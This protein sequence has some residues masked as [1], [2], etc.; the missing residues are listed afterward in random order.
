LWLPRKQD[1]DPL[2]SESVPAKRV[3]WLLPNWLHGLLAVV[4][5]AGALALLVLGWQVAGSPV[6]VMVDGH[7]YEL[8]THAA[9]VAGVL[10]QAGLDLYPE[11]WVSPGP[12]VAL[13]PGL[14]VDVWRAW[15]VKLHVDGRTRHI[16]THATTVGQL[17]AEAGVQAGPADEIW[18]GEQ[19]VGPDALLGGDF[20]DTRAVSSRGGSRLAAQDAVAEPPLISLRRAASL[21][22]DDGGVV[23]RLQTTAQTVGQVL[24]EYG[25]GLFLGDEVTPGLQARVEP[26]MMVAIQRSVPVKIVVDG[27]TIRTRTLAHTV[28]GVLG[29]ESVALVGQ[30][31]VEPALAAPIAAGMAIHITRRRE[32]LVVEFDP[33]PFATILVPD[34][35][36]EIDQQRLVQAGQI[37]L[38]KHRFRVLYENGRET[39]RFLED[40]WAEQPPITKTLA[41]GTKIVVRTLDT[42]AGP[43][44]YWR[45]IRVY[46][47]SYMPASCGKPKSDPRYG[48][49]RLGWKLQKGIVAVDPTVIPLRTT[50]YVPGYGLARAGDTGGAVLGKFVDLG[51]SDNDYQS[52]HWWTDI[53]LLAP[54]PPAS[55]IR[56][57]LPNWPRYPDRR[58]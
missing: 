1:S 49:T 44:E 41:Y 11:D 52:W 43:I 36:L 23:Q 15:P 33:I 5:L 8:R 35:E 18:L 29:Q 16:R 40:T 56:W 30:D 42:P 27:R 45:K 2:A 46:T 50:M 54:V 53:Y 12:E 21:L 38:T 34:P 32:E 26:G 28:A 17:L 13:A 10:Q 39:E 57:V 6:V 58:R 48:Y 22:L 51:F 9:T 55:Q 7:R 37:G 19:Q 20:S 47:T 14:V 31:D 24:Q 25:I 3:N 4:L